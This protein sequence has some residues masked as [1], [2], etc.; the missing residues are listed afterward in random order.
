MGFVSVVLIETNEIHIVSTSGDRNKEVNL[1]NRSRW[2]PSKYLMD[3]DGKRLIE[4]ICRKVE[5][6]WKANRRRDDAVILSLPGTLKDAYSVVSS[7]RLGI[8][9]PVNIASIVSEKLKVP[10]YLFHDTECISLGEIRYGGYFDG[11]VPSNMVYIFVDE[12]VGS[13]IYIDGKLYIGS[14]IAGLLGRLIVNPDGD[15]YPAIRSSGALEMYCGR[16]WVSKRLV[17]VYHGEANKKNNAVIDEGDKDSK[18]RKALSAAARS[19]EVSQISYD[20]IADGVNLNDPIAVQVID[21]SA[22]YLGYSIN[23]VITLINPEVIVLGG[24]MISEVP[25]YAEKAVSY[26]RQLC[27]A[28]AWNATDIKVSANGRDFQVYGAIALY[29][30]MINR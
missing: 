12:G 1:D 29:H 2:D 18:F 19:G 20:R 23:S 16:P 27:W 17:E 25:G 26:A 4:E 5:E 9:E 3:T 21:R 24:A 7:S 15:Y 8:R 13:K 6:F 14:G 30:S 22:R 28:N 11:E 10:C